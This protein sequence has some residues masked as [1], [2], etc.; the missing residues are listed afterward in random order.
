MTTIL[1]GFWMCLALGVI[2]LG[3]AENAWARVCGGPYPASERLRLSTAAFIGKVM[4]I[5]PL[6]PTVRTIMIDGAPVSVGEPNGSQL[7]FAVSETFKG[8]SSNEITALH[9]N[10]AP[11]VPGESYLVFAGPQEGGALSVSSC[12]T[13]PL[14]AAGEAVKYLEG[15]KTSRPQALFHGFAGDRAANQT[16]AQSFKLFVE[17]AGVRFEGPASTSANYEIVLPPGEY[18][19]WLQDGNLVGKSETLRLAAGDVKFSRL[20]HP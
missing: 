20:P 19:I 1:K 10:Y 13:L 12:L 6:P 9:D 3:T 18:R 7:R 4:E 8:T 5:R 17:G 16:R 15:L 14:A 2:L 11:L